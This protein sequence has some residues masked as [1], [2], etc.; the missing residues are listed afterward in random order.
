MD[1]KLLALFSLKYNPFAPDVPTEA[2]RS[3]PK[4]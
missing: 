2:L 1:T 3:T 4:L